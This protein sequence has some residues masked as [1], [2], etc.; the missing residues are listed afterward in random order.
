[1]F[2][3]RWL[4]SWLL[5]PV[6]GDTI[7]WQTFSFDASWLAS[8][9]HVEQGLKQ[10]ST[11]DFRP[12]GTLV[13]KTTFTKAD[14]EQTVTEELSW[15]VKNGRLCQ[16]NADGKEESF[17]VSFEGVSLLLHFEEHPELYRIPMIKLA[18]V[19]QP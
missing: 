14:G 9:D 10:V 17:P 19:E 7:G 2:W 13:S 12:D 15:R 3:L 5:S 4:Y 1:M 8:G 6:C 16:T 18:R 11:M